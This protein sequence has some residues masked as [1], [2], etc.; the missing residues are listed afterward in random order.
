M[1]NSGSPSCLFSCAM[2]VRAP[3]PHSH[4]PPP[5]P[6]PPLL[7]PNE[8]PWQHD[9]LAAD[10]QH[11][12][13]DGKRMV[14][15]PPIHHEHHWAPLSMRGEQ[16]QD[17]NYAPDRPPHENYDPLRSHSREQSIES[18]FFNEHT[19]NQGSCDQRR[20]VDVN[21]SGFSHH[22]QP[23]DIGVPQRESG[24][25]HY[26]NHRPPQHPPVKFGPPE[27]SPGRTDFGADYCE[28]ERPFSHPNAQARLEELQFHQSSH[29]GSLARR[30]PF[31]RPL[32]PPGDAPHDHNH[33]YSPPPPPISDH[34]DDYPPPPP[35]LDFQRER[36]AGRESENRCYFEPR[37]HTEDRR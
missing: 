9:K 21:S 2:Q 5:H 35:H 23:A 12:A 7:P 17:Q 25:D 3:Y 14:N 31:E 18:R 24:F 11:R 13:Q 10:Q 4:P 27:R 33:Q 20:P 30:G 15:G 32:F 16:A 37:E 22:E 6:P 19:C 1:N 8:P 34:Y 28:I 36:Y 26:G 29:G